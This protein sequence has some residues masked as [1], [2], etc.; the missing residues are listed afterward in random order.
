VLVAM[1]SAAAGQFCYALLMAIP[2]EIKCK[3]CG[4]WSEI[5]FEPKLGA[6]QT[7]LMRIEC[8]T[9]HCDHAWEM[10]IPGELLNVE[11]SA[12]KDRGGG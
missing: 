6:G 1:P 4:R 3:K 2:I 12:R 8:A 7:T 10:V 9:P 5:E 11:Q